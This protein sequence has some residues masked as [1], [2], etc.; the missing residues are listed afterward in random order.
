MKAIVY[1]T[2]NLINGIQYIGSTNKHNKDKYYFGSGTL[3]KEAI[4]EHGIANF[5]RET[6]WE[7]PVE[8]RWDMEEY[9][10]KLYNAADSNLFYNVSTKTSKRFAFGLP[11]TF[12]EEHKAKISAANKGRSKGTYQSRKWLLNP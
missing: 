2:T 5:M 4:K 12:S 8:Q 7:G 9:Y 1:I 10:I 6:L 11:R 3:I